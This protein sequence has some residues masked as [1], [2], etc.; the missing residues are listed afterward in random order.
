MNPGFIGEFPDEAE[1]G[2]LNSTLSSSSLLS[3]LELRDTPVY[4]PSIRALLGT[5]SH[6][7]EVV[8]LKLRTPEAG[9]ARQGRGAQARSRASVVINLRNL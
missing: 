6:C 2:M 4:E 5:A 9:G 8:V 3:S 7:C 1:A